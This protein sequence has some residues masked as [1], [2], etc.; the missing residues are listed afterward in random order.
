MEQY[1]PE[2]LKKIHKEAFKEWLDDR[3]KEFGWF[4]IKFLVV[5]I[6]GVLLYFA[7]QHGLM[8]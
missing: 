2:E 4:S 8:K 6:G 5:L 7:S 1:T 3:A